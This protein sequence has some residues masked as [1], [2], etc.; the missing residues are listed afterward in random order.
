VTI[1]R[2]GR[3]I[4]TAP[5][6]EET[7]QSLIQGML[8]RPMSTVF[9]PK[10]LPGPADGRAPALSV[11][12]LFG[13]GQ[14]SDID[15]DLYPGE[16]VGLAGLVGAGRSEMARAVFGADRRDRGTVEIDGRPANF[17][18]PTAASR[19]GLAMVP[20][21]RRD[22]GLLLGRSIQDNLNLVHLRGA[23]TFGVLSKR[24]L[25]DASNRMIAMLDI[26]AKSLNGPVGNLSGGNQQKVLFGKWLVKTPRILIADEPTRGVDVGA[27]RAIYE[28]IAELAAHGVA[29]LLISSEL[30]EILGLAHR[31][32]VMRQG[33]LT[34]SL[35][36]EDITEAAI[37]N[38]AFSPAD[39]VS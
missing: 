33:I 11:R 8:G 24:K 5:A 13:K 21:S 4:R 6:A 29:V 31:V 17:R 2:D 14:F 15:F 28:L 32:L 26:R 22:L 30:E 19:G 9:P 20:E 3:V 36:G 25:R 12:G 1:L 34:A 16:I 38:A 10:Q 18:S 35:R 7:E 37:M 39:L 23:S 27:K